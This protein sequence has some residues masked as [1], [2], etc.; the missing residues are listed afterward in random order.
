MGGQ[1]A[2]N[3][4][5]AANRRC[6]DEARAP[7]CGSG[8]VP[9]YDSWRPPVT[10]HLSGA[11]RA[12]IRGSSYL[13]TGVL[14][15]YHEKN[16]RVQVVAMAESVS[17]RDLRAMM[18]LIR[19]GY[20]DEPAE[21]LPAAAG[22]GLSR[23]VRCDSI[24]LFELS[25]GHRHCTGDGCVHDPGLSPVF[26]THYW[27]CPPCSYPERS[28]DYKSVTKTSDFYSQRQWHSAPMYS[29]YLR[30]F[31]VEDEIVACL[32]AP[33]GRSLRLLLRRDSGGFTERDKLLA[34]LLRPHL[35]AV[36]QDAQRRQAGV[37][38]LTRTPMGAAPAGR[39][40]TQQRRHCPAAIPVGKHRTQTPGEHL[41]AA[42][43]L[44]PHS[45]SRPRFPVRIPDPTCRLARNDEPVCGMTGRFCGG[46]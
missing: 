33:P 3:A 42:Q 44:Q 22:A 16:R 40:R 17:S 41:P 20:A 19:D 30:R 18:D 5:G 23:L 9:G 10:D 35:H 12:A 29:E 24:C 21:G 27:S 13:R 32:P 28:G 26:W 1:P 34:E 2:R 11:G 36:Y 15:P 31:G 8:P 14:E 25:P 6:P 38:R 7:S 39:G 37:P 43:R 46:I 4:V 45:G